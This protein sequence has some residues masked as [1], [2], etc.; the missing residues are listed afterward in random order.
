MKFLKLLG[1]ATATLF[2]SALLIAQSSSAVQA[3]ELEWHRIF[4]IPEAF[5]VVG[6]G[7]GAVGGGAPWTTTSGDA[8][9]DLKDGKDQV[10]RRRIGAGSWG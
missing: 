6:S 3:Q 9:V 8:E 4:G 2:A 5:N 10:Q 1:I 7:T